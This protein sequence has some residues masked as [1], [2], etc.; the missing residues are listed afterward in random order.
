MK[1]FIK[2]LELE[3]VRNTNLE[4]AAQQK[5]YMKGQFDFY[6]MKAPVRRELTKPF[7]LK[8]YLPPKNE[9]ADLVRTL[10][11]KPKRD[12]QYFAMDLSFKYV[13]QLEEKDIELFEF[14]VENQSWWDTVDFVAVKLMG[15]YFKKF[16][17]KIDAYVSKWL[18]SRNI[19]LQRSALLFQL[20]W[21]TEI[22]TV[23]MSST[24]NALTG[25][26]EFFINK[27]IGWI[28]R[29][30]SRTDAV[31]VEDFV[32]KTNLHSLSKREALRLMN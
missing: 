17:E 15:A 13:K 2:T 25:S 27:A 23:L 12:Y 22:N 14:M 28:L 7:L 10:W 26:K 1:D 9:L 5:A 16:P 3:F 20:K 4:I 8:S 11:L 31:W 24:I 19:W 30:Y 29:E 32:R 18:A 21:K 6:G